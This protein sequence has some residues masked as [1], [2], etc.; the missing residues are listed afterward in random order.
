MPSITWPLCWISNVSLQLWSRLRFSATQN[1]IKTKCCVCKVAV[2]FTLTHQT[3]ELIIEHLQEEDKFYRFPENGIL[4]FFTFTGKLVMFFNWE[5]LWRCLCN[6]LGNS[7]FL[8][9]Y[10][11]N[12]EIIA[13]TIY[14]TFEYYSDYLTMHNIYRIKFIRKMNEILMCAKYNMANLLNK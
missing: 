7:S 9:S 14:W 4:V 2:I 13:L 6:I 12:S 5:S 10:D 3:T 1:L 8:N 11:S